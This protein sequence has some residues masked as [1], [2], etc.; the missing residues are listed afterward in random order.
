M[1]KILFA[2]FAINALV[3]GAQNTFET[4]F[5]EHLVNKGDYREAI[6]LVDKNNLKLKGAQADSVYYFKGWSHYSM[7]Q[8]EQS[9][10]ALQ[11][12]SEQSVFYHKARFFAAYNTIHMGNYEQANAILQQTNSEQ[13]LYKNLRTYQQSGIGLLNKDYTAA[14]K[15]LAAT[16]STLSPLYEPLKNLKLIKTELQQHKAKSPVLAGI[17][18]AILPGSGK[19]YVGKKG[20][21]ISTF[22]GTVGLGLITWE[23]YRKLGLANVKTIFFGSVFAANYVSNIYGSAVA[24]KVEENDY[25]NVM[26]N[27]ILFNLHIP[28]R[29]IFE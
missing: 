19:F 10:K 12:V 6:Y 15:Y 2:I 8:L 24:A 4:A 20:Q 16:D 21:A 22:V 25:Q 28:L 5:I 13:H 29:N 27:Q 23:N 17:M 7:M 18:S 9:A 11:K 3:S 14:E 26:Q 1:R